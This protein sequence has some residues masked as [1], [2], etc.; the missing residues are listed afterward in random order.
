MFSKQGLLG[1]NDDFII[2][3]KLVHSR[4]VL[5]ISSRRNENKENIGGDE[6]AW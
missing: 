5:S 2:V 1:L 4:F 3:I 6:W